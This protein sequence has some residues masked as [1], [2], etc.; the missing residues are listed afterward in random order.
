MSLKQPEAFALIIDEEAYIKKVIGQDEDV[1][2][3]HKGDNLVNYIEPTSLNRFMEFLKDTNEDD[4]SFGGEIVFGF[5]DQVIKTT[6]SMLQYGEDIICMSLNESESTLHVL[7]EVI[8]INNQQTNML[9]RAQALSQQVGDDD[10]SVFLEEVTKLNSDLINTQ[11]KLEQRNV[12]LT[13]LNEKLH[14]VGNTD[15]LTNTGNRRK[16]FKDIQTLTKKQSMI[17]I[18]IDFNNFKL[19]NDELGHS[20]GDEVLVKFSTFVQKKVEPIE[21][22]L[23][24]IG[25]DEFAVLT[26]KD[27]PL[28]IEALI[29]EINHLLQKYHKNVSVAYGVVV[30]KKNP[31]I[32]KKEIEES[33]ID[34]DKQMYKNK[35]SLKKTQ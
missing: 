20:K 17:L 28:N 12:E 1:K 32:T 15:Y 10:N 19:I 8:R 24:R 29:T 25:G 21:S 11:R 9:R 2:L 34:V 18:M 13:E 5:K 22:E 23:Y 4:Y 7:N 6:L 26:P 35:S 30:L 16:F 3:F 27:K 31:A 14:R 33:L